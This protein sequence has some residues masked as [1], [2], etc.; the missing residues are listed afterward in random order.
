M[1]VAVRAGTYTAMIATPVN[2]K[3][4]EARIPGS[5]A[6]TP[7]SSPRRTSESTRLPEN[8]KSTPRLISRKP[9]LTTIMRTSR[10]DAPTAIRIPISFVRW[11]TLKAITLYIPVTASRS[12][13]PAKTLSRVV[14]NALRAVDVAMICFI[15]RTFPTERPPLAMRSS[16]SMLGFNECGSVDVRIAKA[17]GDRAVSIRVV[18]GRV[19]IDHGTGCESRIVAE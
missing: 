9:C 18:R 17:S 4:T 14:L 2:S 19:K 16:C 7:Y 1:R 11:R 8:P 6:S 10:G 5:D 13:A 3:A 15:D 12:A